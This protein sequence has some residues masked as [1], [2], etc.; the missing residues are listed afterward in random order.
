MTCKC[1]CDLEFSVINKVG[2]E[3][4]SSFIVLNGR[5]RGSIDLHANLPNYSELAIAKAL[6]RHSIEIGLP[7]HYAPNRL[8]TEGKM[9]VFGVKDKKISLKKAVV[10]VV[11]FISPP[12]LKNV[13]QLF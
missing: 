7:K 3:I 2:V 4:D 13:I 6:A 9:C 8:V 10:I 5:A 12:S 11:K 1:F